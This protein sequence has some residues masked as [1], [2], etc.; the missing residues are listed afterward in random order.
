MIHDSRVD[1]TIK[2]V[3]LLRD[4][5]EWCT[6]IK[7]G[8]EE[9]DENDER[10]EVRDGPMAAPTREASVIPSNVNARSFEASTPASPRSDEANE[11]RVTEDVLGEMG[12]TPA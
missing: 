11:A 5:Y 6:G 10:G 9:P 4:R 2:A 8:D 12:P 3:S 1:R 7:A